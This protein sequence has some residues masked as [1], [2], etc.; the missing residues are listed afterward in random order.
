MK[1]K[2]LLLNLFSIL[3]IVSCNGQEK[4]KAISSKEKDNESSLTDTFNKLKNLYFN[5]DEK[6]I[7]SS[8]LIKN[9][10]KFAVY[11]IPISEQSKNYYNNFE[12]NNNIKPLFDELNST[13]Y[14][15][16]SDK[17]KIDAI[18]KEKIKNIKDFAI[19]GTCISKE[20]ITIESNGEYSVNFP[21]TQK[22]YKK[23]NEK[24]V[25]LFEK[26]ISKTEEEINYN[27]KKY[28]S[29]LSSQNKKVNNSVE[30]Y[31][32]NGRWLI[33]C[34]NGVGK[35]SIKDKVASF[36]V[37]YNQIYID[38]VELKRY[39]AEKGI[40]YKLKEIP[41]D[42]GGLGRDLNWKEYI[43]DEPIA[44]IKMIDNKTIHFY[45]YGFYNKITK[46]REFTETNFNQ[47]TKNKEIVLKL[48][49]K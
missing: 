39:N 21:F 12:K 20:F 23:D 4:S 2:L 3:F 16:S 19:I 27:S 40:T 45:W 6:L 18:L 14:Y 1:L 48:C 42:I 30:S 5:S 15:S 7:F 9:K 17:K 46:K 32:A 26:R 43:N 29:T 24:W 28:I 47:E 35:L 49:P 11:Y 37:I 44:Y 8:E 31:S 41:E 38:M 25:F 34:K 10:G 22:Y 33:D 36:T 13:N